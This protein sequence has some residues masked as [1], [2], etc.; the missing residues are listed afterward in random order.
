MDQTEAQRVE[1][2]FLR[3]P[4][5]HPL[6]YLVWMEAP[7]T[8]LPPYLKVEGLDPPSLSLKPRSRVRI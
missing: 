2:F 3:P 7:P 5:P 8:L 6:T 4:P 1:F